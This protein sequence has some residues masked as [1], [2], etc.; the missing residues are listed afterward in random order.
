MKIVRMFAGDDGHCHFEDMSADRLAELVSNVREGDV[1]LFQSPA[2]GVSEIHNAPRRQIVVM[3]SGEIEF[4]TVPGVKVRLGPG[5]VQVE[6]DL[7][8]SGH[9]ARGIG[10]DPRVALSVPLPPE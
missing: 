7:T 8:G 6:E 3:I 4:E 10:T 2:Q 1:R 9:R 5:D